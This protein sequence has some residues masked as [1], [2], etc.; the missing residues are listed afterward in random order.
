MKPAAC[1]GPLRLVGIPGAWGVIGFIHGQGAS[2][3]ILCA[4]IALATGLG[5]AIVLLA[6]DDTRWTGL[7]AAAILLASP[8]LQKY[9]GLARGESGDGQLLFL[10]TVVMVGGLL[11]LARLG[12][13]HG[14]PDGGAPFRAEP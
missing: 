14:N 8:L 4:A 1:C 13:G 11:L 5:A 10:K 6:G 9:W 3:P 2:F 12:S 7:L